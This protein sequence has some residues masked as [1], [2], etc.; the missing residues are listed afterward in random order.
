[1]KILLGELNA[2]VGRENNLNPTIRNESLQ[3]DSNYKRVKIVNFKRQK[4]E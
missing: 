2:K 4:I 3:E 1:M